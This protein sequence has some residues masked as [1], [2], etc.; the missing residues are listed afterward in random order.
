M[1][2]SAARTICVSPMTRAAGSGVSPSARAAFLT[3]A[4]V[5]IACTRGAPQRSAASQPTWPE[6]Q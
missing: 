5:C 4:M 2:R 1:R 6:S 3:F